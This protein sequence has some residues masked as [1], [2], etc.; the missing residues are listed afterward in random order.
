[1]LSFSG[2]DWISLVTGGG[3][4][5]V[6]MYVNLTKRNDSGLINTSPTAAMSPIVRLQYGCN[7]TLVIP[8]TYGYSHVYILL[9][10]YISTRCN[11]PQSLR[12]YISFTQSVMPIRIT[13]DVDGLNRVN[14]SALVFAKP[15]LVPFWT[16]YKI[17]FILVFY[18]SYSSHLTRFLLLL[19]WMCLE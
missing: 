17:I 7:H 15:F 3:S 8:G 10:G 2:G 12:W 13:Y 16:R 11:H 5:E 4:W 1:L 18:L 19:I 6:R 9:S 14:L